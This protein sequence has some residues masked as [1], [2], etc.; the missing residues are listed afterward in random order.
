MSRKDSHK[1]I[2]AGIISALDSPEVIE[3]LSQSLATSILLLL[4][5]KLK[6]FLDKIDKISDEIGKINSKLN[7][8][9]TE[10]VNLKTTV[11]SLEEKLA[12]ANVQINALEQTARGNNLVISGIPETFAER[13]DPATQGAQPSRD[14]TLKSIIS[15]AQETCGITLLPANIHAAFRIASRKPG[16]RPI[17]VTLHSAEI[18]MRLLKSR[19]PREKLSFR[20]NDIF[21]NE[22]WT[23]LN[24]KLIYMARQM[25][26]NHQAHSTWTKD[27]HIFIR[28]TDHDRPS[29]IV[30]ESDFN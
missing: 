7:A 12:K 1:D 8:V 9:H 3:K 30:Q 18:R 6:P 16:P 17:L 4:D 2:A 23:H 25:V 27:G 5:E 13:A 26:K 22:H 24:S 10:H 14:D 21:I 15:V 28:W 29:R 20:G 11:T 19:R